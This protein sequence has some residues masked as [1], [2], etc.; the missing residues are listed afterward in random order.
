MESGHLKKENILSLPSLIFR[1]KLTPVRTTPK[2]DSYHKRHN[3]FRLFSEPLRCCMIGLIISLVTYHNTIN[4]YLYRIQFDVESTTPPKTNIFFTQTFD[5]W[6]MFLLFQTRYFQVPMLIL[7]GVL[8][9]A[10]LF[11]KPAH[12]TVR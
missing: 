8:F 2:I 7:G 10:N 3:I 6:S 4:L 5:G 1:F 9:I 11:H 12:E